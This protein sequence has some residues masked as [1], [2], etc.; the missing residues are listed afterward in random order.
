VDPASLAIEGAWFVVTAVTAEQPQAAV[1]QDTAFEDGID[2]TCDAHCPRRAARAAS[3]HA[4][5][6]STMVLDYVAV[7]HAA[8]P[9]STPQRMN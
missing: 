4:R 3:Q 9:E 5:L 2:R 8:S 1:R 7:R 6:D